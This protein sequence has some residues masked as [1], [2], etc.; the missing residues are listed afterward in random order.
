MGLIKFQ[1]YHLGDVE[2]PFLA[3]RN[4]A[5]SSAILAG[6]ALAV[7]LLAC[8]NY[9]NLALGRSAARFKE[10]AVRKTIGSGQAGLIRLFLTESILQTL[11]ASVLGLGLALL[12]LPAFNSFT[13]KSLSHPDFRSGWSAVF[14]AGLVLFTG[15]AAGGYPA[16]FLSRRSVVDIFGG[17]S[18]L[19]RKS[20][21]SRFILVLQFTAS[22]VFIFGTVVMAAQ[23]R[24]L[25]SKDLGFDRS[26]VI[27]VETQLPMGA[28]RAGRDML[29]FFKTELRSR[30]G[31]VAVAGD[32][33]LMGDGFGSFA[34]PF[35]RDGRQIDVQ[36]YLIDEDYLAALGLSLA[37]GR[38]FSA[39]FGAD[40]ANAALVNET[41]VR[42]FGIPDP[43]GKRF[44]E[45]AADNSPKG[46]E[47]DPMIIGVVKDFHIDSLHFEIEPSAFTLF[48]QG[49]QR[50]R[51]ILVK[52]DNRDIPGALA[53]I[54]K[55][56][57]KVSPDRPFSY[58]FLDDALRRQYGKERNWSRILNY[59]AGAA[60]LIASLGLFGMA[61][62]AAAR[63]TKEIGV[64]KVLGASAH[65]IILT[66]SREFIVLLGLAHLL[67]W[68]AAYYAGRLWLRGF[69]YNAG[70]KPWMFI[71]SSALIVIV[72]L[73]TLSGQA[74]R[75]TRTDPVKA[76]RSE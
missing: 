61:A 17:R 74:L 44:S 53:Q 52:I 33:G 38:N 54:K 16:V 40:A 2:A 67:A 76:L 23:L 46:F 69:P 47:Y 48:D 75:A 63:R 45:F 28:S 20:V 11:L 7:L 9:M 59:S 68:P 25:S 39:E 8:F 24:H 30:P 70:L 3:L 43:V 41:L 10:I 60:I 55:T 49:I 58:E 5:S 32:S 19:G 36:A 71:L 50:Y 51:R 18:S 37:Q 64:R 1:D 73:L 15:L 21:F 65:R 4:K 27:A 57:E 35:V 29:N 62:L 22:L 26:G 42:R 12:L 34:H 13:G 31:I 56:W 72:S 6:I 14:L 66:M